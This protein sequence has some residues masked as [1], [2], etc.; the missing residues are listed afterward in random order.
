MGATR[1]DGK[2]EGGRG[3]QPEEEPGRERQTDGEK[4]IMLDLERN[5]DGKGT[6]EKQEPQVTSTCWML[7]LCPA[8]WQL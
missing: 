3:S 6:G 8:G 5:S 7:A 2:G 4:Q 1:Q